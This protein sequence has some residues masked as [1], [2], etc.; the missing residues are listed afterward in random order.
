MLTFEKTE[1]V[2]FHAAFVALK[3]RC[4]LTISVNPDDYRL[5][6]EDKLFSAY[7]PPSSPSSLPSP[8]PSTQISTP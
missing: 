5:A 7:A 3:A 2:I 6:G 1:L 8:H 4:P